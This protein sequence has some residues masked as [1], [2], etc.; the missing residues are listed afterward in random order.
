MFYFFLGEGNEL[1]PG[2]VQE[3]TEPHEDERG[4]WTQ[5]EFSPLKNIATNTFFQL[6]WKYLEK[7]K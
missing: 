1:T 3:E 7:G 6:S 4:N 5:V 2:K